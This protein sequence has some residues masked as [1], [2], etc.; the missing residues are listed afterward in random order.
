MSDA[1]YAIDLHLDDETDASVK[2]AK[3]LFLLGGQSRRAD[4]NAAQSGPG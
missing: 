3:E 2:E 1:R 4:A